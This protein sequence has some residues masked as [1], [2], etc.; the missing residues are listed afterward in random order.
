MVFHSIL[1]ENTQTGSAVEAAQEPAS[2]ADLNLDQVINAITAGRQEYNLKPFFYAPLHDA[3]TIGY[4]QQ[5]MQDL[6]DESL[7]DHIKSFAQR[8]SATR[9]CLALAEKLDFRYHR[10]GWFL[11]A[12]DAF[13][14]AVT[15]LARDLRLADLESRG[16]V[17][18]RDYL[19]AYVQA[20][21]FVQL[22]A[23]TQKL[24]AD[25]SGIRYCVLIKGN[26]VRVRRYEDEIDYSADVEA[27]FEKFKQSAV[28]DYRVKL[29][30]RSG[31]S[32]VEAQILALVAKLYP[33]TFASLDAFCARHA[34]FVDQ[35]IGVFDREIQFYV[36][37]LDHIAKIKR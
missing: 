26:L 6:E 29:P 10:E 5:V 32:H 8:M 33:D 21:A 7:L 30:D 20:D 1:Y 13:C 4:R 37:Y 9:R 28:K 23:E 14:D 34:S 36:A 18:F 3:G 2:F 19:A 27:T 31:M 16:L 17:A 35:T 25:L 22:R 12:A 15:S 24:K 11:E